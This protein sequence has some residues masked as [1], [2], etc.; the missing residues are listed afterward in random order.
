MVCHGTI[1]QLQFDE[2][3]QCLGY[4]TALQLAPRLKQTP[5]N[6]RVTLATSASTVPFA[7][8]SDGWGWISDWI[9]AL[10]TSTPSAWSGARPIYHPTPRAAAVV[11]SIYGWF[12]SAAGVAPTVLLRSPCQFY[13]CY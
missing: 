13:L 12:A 2:H 10:F 9:G 1:P 7:S 8:L 6:D 3:L 4:R 5:S 11:G